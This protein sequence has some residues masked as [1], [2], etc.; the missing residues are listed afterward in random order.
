MSL[1]S[2]K[3]PRAQDPYN[4]IDFNEELILFLLQMHTWLQFPEFVSLS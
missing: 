4:I 1:S 3:S 2:S